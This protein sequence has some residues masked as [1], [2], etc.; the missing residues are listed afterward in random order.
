MSA[1]ASRSASCPAPRSTPTTRPKPPARPA[2]TPEIASSATTARSAGTPSSLAASRNVSGAGL[3]LSP[4]RGATDP[5][6]TTSNRGARPDASS[7]SGAL[8]DDDTTAIARAAFGQ[9]VEQAHRAGVRRRC[10]R[11]AGSSGTSRSS[12][13]RATPI[14]SNPG[15]SSWVPSGK[16]DGAGLRRTTGRRRSA[17]C[18]RRRAGSPTAAERSPRRARWRGT[19]RTS[20]ST[21]V[22]GSRR[23]AS[24]RR[25]DRTAP[26]RARSS[27]RWSS[28]RTLRDDGL[29]YSDTPRVSRHTERASRSRVT[30]ARR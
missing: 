12:C 13:C 15:G 11:D 3:P 29:R 4:S 23:S 6:T 9:R 22:R 2:A 1:P 24:A 19:S 25:R 7:T 16:L 21:L 5:S 28:P 27:R 18:R 10:R 30:Q 14:D 26:R 17:A 8:R 20:P